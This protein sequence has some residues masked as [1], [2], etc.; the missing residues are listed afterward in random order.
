M[1]VEV[2]VSGENVIIRGPQY[3]TALPVCLS[4]LLSNVKCDK[5][6]EKSVQILYHTKDHSA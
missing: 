6:E 4:V 3:F 2:M 1:H 5:T